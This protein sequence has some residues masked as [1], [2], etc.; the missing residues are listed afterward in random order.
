MTALDFL[1]S[2]LS[3][4]LV[5]ISGLVGGYAIGRRSGDKTQ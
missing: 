1:Y 4:L 5:F 3:Y 2:P